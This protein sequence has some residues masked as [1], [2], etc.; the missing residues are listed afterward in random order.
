MPSVIFA[1]IMRHKLNLT[2]KVFKTVHIGEKI[3]KWFS[4]CF[5]KGILQSA[6]VLQN[7]CEVTVLL[8]QVLLGDDL[9]HSISKGI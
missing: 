6:I 1:Y 2:F 5:R 4:V 9:I 7:T 8:V 3:T